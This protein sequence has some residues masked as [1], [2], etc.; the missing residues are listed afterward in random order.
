MQKNL[1]IPSPETLGAAGRCYWSHLFSRL[2]KSSSLSL[3]SRDKNTSH[4]CVGGLLWN[5][6]CLSIFFLHGGAENRL[7]YPRRGK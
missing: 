1:Q 2:N 7:Q 3:S 6:S 4:D 5:H